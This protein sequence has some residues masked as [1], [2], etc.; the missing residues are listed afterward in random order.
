MLPGIIM[1]DAL[2]RANRN[3]EALALVTRLLEGSRTPEEGVFVPELWRLRGELVLRQSAGDAREAERHYGTA[4]RLA[5]E[6][7]ALVYRLRA[8]TQLSRLLAEQGR[9]EEARTA[10][11]HANAN[12]LDEWNGPEIGI[13]TQLRSELG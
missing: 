12:P 7:G 5:A 6:Q 8:G 4:T 2:A 1:V 3:Q 10:L 9:R 11:D 13:A